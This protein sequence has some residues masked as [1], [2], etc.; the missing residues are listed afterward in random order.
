MF[1][2][3]AQLLRIYLAERDRIE[4]IPLHEWVLN[5]AFEKGIAGATAIKGFAGFCAHSPAAAPSLMSSSVNLPIVIEIVEQP[6]AIE[7]FVESIGEQIPEGLM[8]LE[9]VS[10]KFFNNR[11]R[12][13]QA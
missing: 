13:P 7:K 3:K 10:I 11:R 8:T 2:E 4:G 6:E 1:E 9:N 5:Q 12:T